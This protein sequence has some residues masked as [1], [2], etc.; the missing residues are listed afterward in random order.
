[1]Q[2]YTELLP[3]S[4]VTHALS[5][6]FLS[7]TSNNLII[8][9]TSLLQVFSLVNVTYGIGP[10]QTEEKSRPQ[11]TK[12]VLVAEYAL[13]GTVTGLGRVK[14]LGS[15]SGGEAVLVAIRNAKLSLIEWDPEIHRIS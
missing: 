7:A 8:A 4:G 15:K 3:P 5:I 2:C 11:Y 10:T 9:K 6:P 13:P 14:I 12:L 1:M